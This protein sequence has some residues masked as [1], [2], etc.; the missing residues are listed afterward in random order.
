[1]GFLVKFPIRRACV[2]IQCWI[3]H[4]LLY[5]ALPLPIYLIYSLY[6]GA[7]G[8]IA[9]AISRGLKMANSHLNGFK[10]FGSFLYLLLLK[11][12]WFNK[13]HIPHTT[14]T[15]SEDL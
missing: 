3:S 8:M 10:F 1:M 9:T 15:Y 6:N 14:K 11:W 5:F 7:K 13:F 12:H 4:F 2:I